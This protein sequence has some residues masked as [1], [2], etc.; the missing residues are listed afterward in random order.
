MKYIVAKF[1]IDCN[2]EAFPA[3]CEV[4]ASLAADAGF[5]AF[6]DWDGGIKA[7]AQERLFSRES[8]D[9][10]I[11]SFFIKDVSITYNIEN[12]EDKDWNEDWESAGFAPID[13]DGKCVIYDAK[14]T[15]KSQI[16]P[17]QATPIFIEA[18]QSF[19]TGTHQ[20]TRMV[21]S[22]LLKSSLEGCKVLDCGCGTGILGIVA[23]VFGASA[24]TAYD[25]DN[26]CVENT[27]HNASLNGVANIDVREG[28]ADILKDIGTE[29][30]VVVANINRNILIADIPAF[31]SRMRKGARLIMSGF[32]E[33]DIPMI[34]ASAERCG[35][36]TLSRRAC[37]EWACVTVR[38]L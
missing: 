23:A 5:E 6:E 37:D 9:R 10:A 33:A 24:V 32:Y 16:T 21:V 36:A 29:F 18:R 3:A 35:M 34:I 38:K 28:C 26:W 2:E 31:C 11:A 13:I 19:G 8:L 12:V 17:S 15:D 25:V 4:L 1:S 14:H 27:L 22:E 30:D 20:T 7:Y